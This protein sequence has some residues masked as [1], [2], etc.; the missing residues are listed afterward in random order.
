MKTHYDVLGVPFG[1]DPETVRT[2]YRKALKICHPDLHKNDP[3]AEAQSKLIIDAYAVLKDPALRTVYDQYL[4]HRRQQ[5]RRLFGIAVLA[6]AG[7]V[8]GGT[9]IWLQVSNGA[10]PSAR[11]LRRPGRRAARR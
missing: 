1:A 2:A 7:M 3:A 10:D 4:L 6:G 5:R 9:L 11:Q 8:L